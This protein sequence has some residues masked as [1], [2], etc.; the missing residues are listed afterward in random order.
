[1]Q[2]FSFNKTLLNTEKVTLREVRILK[3]LCR[4]VM[5][6]NIKSFVVS[7]GGGGGWGM[8]IL[9]N[10]LNSQKSNPLGRITRISFIV[11]YLD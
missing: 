5:F 7:E 6:L 8:K 11:N 1:M 4:L 9:R 10:S 2:S 3:R